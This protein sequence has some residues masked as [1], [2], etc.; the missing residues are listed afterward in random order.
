LFYGD[1][2]KNG[3]GEGIRTPVFIVSAK[4]YYML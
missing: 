3:G 4:R 2:F 1:V